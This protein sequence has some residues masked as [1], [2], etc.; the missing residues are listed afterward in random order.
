MNAVTGAFGY[1]GKYIARRL[2]ALGEPVMT[3]TGHPDRAS[4]FG[5]AVKAYPFQFDRP[6]AMA[7]SLA[8]VRVLY[9][10]YWIRFD[11]GGNTH[12]RAVENT[13]ALLRAAELA[14]VPRV[15]HVS[16]TNP[17]AASPLPYFRGKAL[18]E[19][20]VK[21]AG[22]TYA[23]LRPTV[24]FSLEDVLINNIAYLLRKLPMFVVP[25]DGQYRLQPIFVEDFARLAVDAGQGTASTTMDAVGPE[26]F[27]Y[28]EL[29]RLVAKSV[30]SRAAILHAP[31]QFVLTAAR[32]LGALLHD[33]VLTR[34][35]AEGLMANLLVSKSP[36]T[37]STRLSEWL[38]AN[39]ANVGGSYA[40]ELRRH[41]A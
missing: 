13:R 20:A 30:G 1:T 23:I 16:I 26:I 11:R 17:D 4:E 12:Q 28:E 21:N 18:L 31:P 2:L 5:A 7:E 38:V 25:G 41:Y 14:R 40:S 19:E 33:V 29:V 9:N 6:E 32:I 39:A 10:T 36:P 34:D 22:F 35:E 15:V 27:T 8:G 3:L 37:G 24:L